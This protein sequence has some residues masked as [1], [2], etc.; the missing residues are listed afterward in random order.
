MLRLPLQIKLC[1]N[2][3][4]CLLALFI[5]LDNVSLVAFPTDQNMAMHINTSLAK[6]PHPQVVQVIT[7]IT[8][9]YRLVFFGCFVK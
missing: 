4:F 7:L 5:A 6:Q 8:F 9:E 1:S 3:G 2:N